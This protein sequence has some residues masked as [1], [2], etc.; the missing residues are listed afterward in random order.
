VISV[1][2]IF[3][4]LTGIVLASAMLPAAGLGLAVLGILGSLVGTIAPFLVPFVG[5]LSIPIVMLVA[6]LAILVVT[7]LAYALA[8]VSL[9]GAVVVAGVIT[10]NPIELVSR[11]VILGLT[12]ATNAVLVSV[13]TGLPVLGLVILLIGFLTS[14]PPIAAS[15]FIFQPLVGL[16]S[17]AMPMTWLVMPL[18][19]LLFVLNL[20]FAIAQSGIGAIRFDFLTATIETSGGA[21]LNFLFSI[22]PAPAAGFNLGNFSFLVL[23]P[24]FA[25]GTAQSGFAAA[26]LSAH[27]TGHTLTVAAFGGFFGWINAVD[28]NIPPLARGSAAYGEIIPEGHFGAGA[29]P[30]LTMW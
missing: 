1:G 10:T 6:G 23:P 28:E 9:L 14:I 4:A 2:W 27:E 8:A 18:G 24:G 11:G 26:G 21:L 12:S 29:P 30:F 13:L 20:P 25:L 16:L 15:R 22:S 19:V 17:W 5:V 7:I 3:G